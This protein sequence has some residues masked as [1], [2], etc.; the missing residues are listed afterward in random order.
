MADSAWQSSPD[1]ESFTKFQGHLVTMFGVDQTRKNFCDHVEHWCQLQSNKWNVGRKVVPNSR[2]C[3]NNINK[4]D[5]QINSLGAQNEEL[6][7]LLDSKIFVDAIS[8]VVASSMKLTSLPAT[9]CDM[10]ENQFVYISKSYL[11]KPGHLKWHQ[12]PMDL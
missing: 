6:R 8:Q 9:I 1:G 10:Q 7:R 3:Q 4:Q 12:G 5:T 11:G 2:Q